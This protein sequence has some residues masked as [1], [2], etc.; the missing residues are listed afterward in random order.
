MFTA[1]DITGT[2]SK[3]IYQLLYE[4]MRKQS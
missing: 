3:T 1:E 2:D 4:S